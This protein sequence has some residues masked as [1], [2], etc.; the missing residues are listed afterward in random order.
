M[1]DM[2]DK[3]NNEILNDISKYSNNYGENLGFNQKKCSLTPENKVNVIKKVK[4]R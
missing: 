3:T 2:M 1:G 4:K